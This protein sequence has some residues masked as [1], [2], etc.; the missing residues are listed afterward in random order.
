VQRIQEVAIEVE[1]DT[2]VVIEA[3]L[4]LQVVEAIVANMF[5]VQRWTGSGWDTSMCSPYKTIE[6]ANEH[7]AR[8]WW[9]YTDKNPYRVIKR[10]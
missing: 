7:V 3:G 8:Y 5:Y 9:H 6:E 10:S 2:M 4:A 1:V